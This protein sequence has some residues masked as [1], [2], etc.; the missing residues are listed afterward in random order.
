M[1]L[2]HLVRYLLLIVIKFQQAEANTYD[3]TFNGPQ[4]IFIFNIRNSVRRVRKRFYTILSLN[5]FSLEDLS[6]RI[7]FLE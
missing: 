6:P 3:T 2:Y 1:G 5:G 7:I 4:A